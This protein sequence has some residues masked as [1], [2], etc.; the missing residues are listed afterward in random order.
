LRKLKEILNLD[1]MY[2]L[3]KDKYGH[4]GNVSVP[5]PVIMKM[6]ILLFLYNVRSERE[7]METIPERWWRRTLRRTPLE[8]LTI[9]SWMSNTRNW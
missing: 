8:N 4:N 5:P 2:G 6:M 1:F 9:L 3:L 7:M